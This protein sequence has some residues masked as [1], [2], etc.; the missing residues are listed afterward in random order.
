MLGAFPA[1]RY[2]LRRTTSLRHTELRSFTMVGPLISSWHHLF[3][4]VFLRECTAGRLTRSSVLGGR[5]DIDFDKI[6]GKKKRILD[7][8]P[9]TC[10]REVA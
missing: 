6:L 2:K 9:E 10:S 4:S 8:A 1:A 5:A 3:K 7:G